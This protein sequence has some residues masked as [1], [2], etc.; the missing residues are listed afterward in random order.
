M[1]FIES[2]DK[3]LSERD[4]IATSL[5][6]KYNQVPMP[7]LRLGDPDT[8]ALITYLEMKGFAR[9]VETETKK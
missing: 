8:A 2:P 7:N 9:N 5:Y 1:H 4:P 3:M 6:A